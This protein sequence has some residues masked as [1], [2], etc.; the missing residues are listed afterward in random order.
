MSLATLAWQQPYLNTFK[1][2]GITSDKNVIKQ[3][4]VSCVMVS[5]NVS[6]QIDR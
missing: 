5:S 6:N 1:Y 4:E 3:G 2:F